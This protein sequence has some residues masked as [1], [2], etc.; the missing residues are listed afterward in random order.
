MIFKVATLFVWQTS[1]HVLRNW[2]L[3]HNGRFL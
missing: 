2:R 3:W 1:N